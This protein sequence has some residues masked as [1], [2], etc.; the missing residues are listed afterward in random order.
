MQSACLPQS[1]IEQMC[2]HVHFYY[3]SLILYFAS[4]VLHRRPPSYCGLLFIASQ[5]SRVVP[6]WEKA[7]PERKMTVSVSVSHWSFTS[8]FFKTAQF[9]FCITILDPIL[10][11]CPIFFHLRSWQNDNGWVIYSIFSE[12]ETAATFLA[13]LVSQ[14][15][16]SPSQLV[17]QLVSPLLFGASGPIVGIA[18]MQMHSGA[19]L[20][21]HSSRSFCSQSW[22]LFLIKSRLLSYDN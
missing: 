7:L 6:A 1:N 9:S 8:I 19:L 21:L 3:F 5:L 17:I 20:L 2:L 11:A 12:T 15:L 10:S 22:C 14:H 18:S 16:P 4:T 13:F